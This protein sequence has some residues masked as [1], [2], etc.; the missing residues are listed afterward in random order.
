MVQRL[1]YVNNDDGTWGTLLVSYLTKE[2]YDT[3][4]D[5]PL[6][7]GHKTITIRP[8]T[9]TAGTAPLKFQSGV[10]LSTAEAGAFEYNGTDFFMT[11]SGTNR[12]AIVG[13][14]YAQSLSNKTL[15]AP[16]IVNGGYIADANG[17]EEIIFN[18]TA[19]AV[20]EVTVTNAA[21]GGAPKINA[22]G[23]DANLALSLQGKGST[24]Y[25]QLLDSNGA[26]KFAT[27]ATTVASA[28]NYPYAENAA[29]G[30]P[31]VIGSWGAG[32]D[33]D[34]N[35]TTKGAGLVKANGVT[36]GTQADTNAL[37]TTDNLILAPDFETNSYWA[38]AFGVSS[39]AQA[40]SGTKSRMITATGAG[41]TT[42]RLTL[43][44][45]FTGSPLKVFSSP[46]RNYQAL[47][48]LRKDAANTGS[49]SPALHFTL[50]WYNNSGTEATITDATINEASLSSSAWTD[51]YVGGDVPAN[52]V[53]IALYVAISS[54]VPV[55]NKYYVDQAYLT[56][57]TMTA[58][59]GITM[60]N[61]TLD[62]TNT[63]S[64]KDTNF[65]IQDD[66]DTTKRAKFDAT[67]LGTGTTT[68]F[69]FPNTGGSPTTLVGDDVTQTLFNKTITNKSLAK[70]ANFT[71]PTGD[72]TQVY[73]VDATSA[74]IPG[75]TITVPSASANPGY[76][77]TIKRIDNSGFPI[78]VNSSAGTIDGNASWTLDRQYTSI[79]VVSDAANWYII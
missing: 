21:T 9:A 31:A 47:I 70:T 71:I 18:T 13:D 44:H 3:G 50:V 25:V 61:K 30:S 63:I 77:F 12:Y 40:Y 1:P 10:N 78:T 53:S 65:T 60:L 54:P 22:S 73:F 29:S 2:H 76:Q 45:D 58:S 75:V 26:V 43:T 39:T 36:I 7:G 67:F 59:W 20:N 24:G 14:T 74:G 49:V 8:G 34:L 48:K 41:T 4:L 28:V 79:T 23:G 17:N 15:T 33:V 38:N 72:T 5:D 37:I 55:G 52:A 66:V 51:F 35:L 42:D 19:S 27:A 32:T 16:K 64:L 62:N 56:D 69:E 68:T 46:G 57:A 6:N 11:P